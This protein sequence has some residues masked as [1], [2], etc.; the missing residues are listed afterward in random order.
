MFLTKYTKPN[1]YP[2]G[3]DIDKLF[4]ELFESSF[5][6]A[7]TNKYPATDVYTK[8]GVTYIEVAV[9]GFSD[10]NIEVS[11]E[12]DVLIIK[13]SKEESQESDDRNYHTKNIAR[14]SFVRKFTVANSVEDIEAEVKNGILQLKLIEKEK[15][16]T[17]KLIKINKK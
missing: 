4:D 3:T 14:R 17:K 16:K 2:I 12:N 1:L 7:G 8:D 15:E 13:G 6:E 5:K 10:D 11:M 9:S